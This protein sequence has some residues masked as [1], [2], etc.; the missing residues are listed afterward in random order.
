[1]PS[2]TSTSAPKESTASIEQGSSL[3]KDAWIRLRKN[4]LAM[5]GFFVIVAILFACFILAPI[6]KFSGWDPNGQ[7]LANKFAAPSAQHPLGTDQ[8]GRDLFIRILDGGQISLLV[9][10]LATALTVTFGVLYGSISGY[11]GGKID[12]VMMRIVD[13]LLA[14][15]F[16]IIVILFRDHKNRIIEI[17]EDIVYRR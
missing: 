4:K 11:I 13:G 2:P 5:A 16:L 12:G 14:M 10:L 8:L 6:L 9:A 17:E 7:D 1:M 15:P 3:W